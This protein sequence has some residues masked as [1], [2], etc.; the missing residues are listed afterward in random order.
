MSY[1]SKLIAEQTGAGEITAALAGELI[2]R[3]RAAL[4]GLSRRYAKT[5]Q[6]LSGDLRWTQNL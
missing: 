1:Y 2:R 6:A 4:D 5:G 3:D